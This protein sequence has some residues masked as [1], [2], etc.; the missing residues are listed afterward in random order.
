[1]NKI[2]K[3]LTKIGAEYEIRNYST[4]CTSAIEV[5]KK[6]GFPYD[7]MYKSL[8]C[9]NENSYILVVIPSKSKLNNKYKLVETSL[10]EK[11]TGY[12]IGAVSPILI[13]NNIQVLIDESVNKYQKVSIG[14][15]EYG[16]ELIISPNELIRITNGV[17]VKH[18][19]SNKNDD[20][21]AL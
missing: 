1:M 10:V 3:Y 6:I 20:K 21:L 5:S 8:L 16:K 18:L 2:E 17:I 7:Q 19:A 13:K 14:C 12:P 15:G 9:R 4:N 11:L